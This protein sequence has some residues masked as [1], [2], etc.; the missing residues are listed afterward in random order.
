LIGLELGVEL[1][2][3]FI[4]QFERLQLHVI[5]EIVQIVGQHGQIGAA[6]VSFELLS[7]KG[8]AA[9]RHNRTQRCGKVF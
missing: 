9:H 2:S 3:V 1:Q 4:A 5:A 8:A 7:P 6:L